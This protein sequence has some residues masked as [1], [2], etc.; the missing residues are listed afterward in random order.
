MESSL[1]E[2]PFIP[3]QPKRWYKPAPMPSVVP[4]G[5][6]E[7]TTWILD[8]G[9]R[10][11]LETPAQH[12]VRCSKQSPAAFLVGNGRRHDNFQARA[13][14]PRLQ[15]ANDDPRTLPSEHSEEYTARPRSRS[16]GSYE[17]PPRSNTRSRHQ[18]KQEPLVPFVPPRQCRQHKPAPV[19][20]VIPPG[21]PKG[22]RWVVDSSGRPRLET[23]EQYQ[24]RYRIPPPS[25]SIAGQGTQQLVSHTPNT[26]PWF[27]HP[28]NTQSQSSFTQQPHP[29]YAQ[30]SAATLP[31]A[32]KPLF[33]RIFG[34]IIG[35]NKGARTPG[36]AQEPLVSSAPPSRASSKVNQM[37][38]TKSF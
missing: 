38:R 5:Y 23:P 11:K 16:P 15:P 4:P 25:A 1:V 34:G 36:A 37:S 31:Q 19:P 33:K 27:P 29:I 12:I 14:E 28:H 20:S 13:V 9:G 35:C 21:F 7:G 8:S 6:P 3:P 24:A 18:A 10:P 32:S 26:Q 30:A 2:T 22:T 17:S